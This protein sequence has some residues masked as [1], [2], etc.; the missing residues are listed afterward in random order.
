MTASRGARVADAEWRLSS[1]WAWVVFR[2]VVAVL[3]GLLAF[4]RPGATALALI[5]LFGT[6]AFAGGVAALATALRRDRRGASRDILLLDG[7]VGIVIAAFS[8]YWP[9]RM[10]VTFAW[11]V[12]AWAIASGAMEITNA[13]QL[14]RLFTHE[15]SLTLAGVAS[16]AFG[17]IMVLRPLAGGLAIMWSL[18]AYALAFG[19][20]SIALGVHLR[21][22]LI[23]MR[24]RGRRV[25]HLT[26][27]R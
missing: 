6:Y 3:F 5:L 22:F 4:A 20:L 9:G 8:V 14:R 11:V 7:V 13:M 21:T 23:Q 24:G 12:G 18:G 26:I 15:W 17:L 25:P 27:A 1:H 10:S 2:G 19:A 16:V